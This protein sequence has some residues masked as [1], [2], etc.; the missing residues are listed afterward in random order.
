MLRATA[1][2]RVVPTHPDDLTHFTFS[3]KPSWATSGTVTLRSGRFGAES[4]P[5]VTLVSQRDWGAHILA[6]L[7]W[8]SEPFPQGSHEDYTIPV[9]ATSVFLQRLSL[10]F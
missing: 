10:T 8:Q 5:R 2:D 4:I 9:A 3:I 7:I 1:S 6:L